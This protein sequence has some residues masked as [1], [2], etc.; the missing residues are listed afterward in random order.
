MSGG[1]A[2]K[3]KERK[4]AAKAKP[5]NRGRIVQVQKPKPKPKRVIELPPDPW[6][7]PTADPVPYEQVLAACGDRPLELAVLA[8]LRAS[9]RGP[10]AVYSIEEAMAAVRWLEAQLGPKPPQSFLLKLAFFNAPTRLRARAAAIV[11]LA[12]VLALVLVCC[13][14]ALAWHVTKVATVDPSGVLTD[15]DGKQRPAAV[16][17]AVRL[18]SLLDYPSLSSDELRRAQDTVLKTGGAFHLFRLAG[19]TKLM[20]GGSARLVGEDGAVIRVERTQV[21]VALPFAREEAV[22]AAGMRLLD[23][24]R[25][26]SSLASAGA[27]RA[28]MPH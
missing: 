16:A 5:A 28:Y 11:A 8:R 6:P 2:K 1:F 25:G 14:T 22:D 3:E 21:S 27:F 15:V 17:A 20:S 18:H 7:V 24:A 13:F 23:D 26:A 12:V 19:A 9:E 10:G 4:A